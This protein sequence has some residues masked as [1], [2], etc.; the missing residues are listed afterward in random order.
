M[1]DLFDLA[2]QLGIPAAER[3]ALVLDVLDVAADEPPL[4][5]DRARTARLL[6]VW[7]ARESAGRADAVGDQGRACGVLQ[8][9][10]VAR[11]GRTCADLR[12]SR[13]V[14]L[15]AGLAWMRY[16]AE[17]CGSV[18][19]GLRAYASGSCAGTHRAR[20]LVQARCALIG[21]CS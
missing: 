15:R 7:A 18:V 16:T 5:G 2:A 14:G 8:L 3:F 10:E 11:G 4:W 9:H 6:V 20:E 13:R 21:G 1:V 17:R 19:A 12:A